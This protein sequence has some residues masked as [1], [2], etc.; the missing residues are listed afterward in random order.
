MYKSNVLVLGLGSTPKTIESFFYLV[1]RR[2][3]ERPA[4]PT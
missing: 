1:C 4:A 3:A 2:A